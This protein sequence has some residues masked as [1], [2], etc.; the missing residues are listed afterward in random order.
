MSDRRPLCHLLYT[1]A[2]GEGGTGLR[3]LGR[4]PGTQAE[5]ERVKGW[6]MGLK[7]AD[8]QRVGWATSSFLVDR[9]SCFA[10][11]VVD[12]TRFPKDDIGRP[13]GILAH[14]L[15]LLLEQGQPVGDF[16]RAAFV[17]AKDFLEE[18]SGEPTL[19]NYLQGC[20]VNT[21]LEIPDL[22]YNNFRLDPRFLEIFYSAAC[23]GGRGEPVL[24]PGTSDDQLPEDLFTASTI[25]PPRLR[26]DLSWRVGLDAG[27]EG[28]VA[29]VAPGPVAS[30]FGNLGTAYL[31]AVQAHL[32][33][34]K[35]DQV[36]RFAAG[37]WNVRSWSG[38][39][40][41]IGQPVPEGDR[42]IVGPD[43]TALSEE[44]DMTKK[45]GSASGGKAAALTQTK[46]QAAYDEEYQALEKDL[47]DYL[48]EHLTQLGAPPETRSRP[49]YAPGGSS[50]GDRHPALRWYREWRPEVYFFVLLL[51]GSLAFWNLRS[52][53]NRPVEPT[54][55][56]SPSPSPTPVEPDP[57]PA[58][59]PARADSDWLPSWKAFVK[60][61]AAAGWFQAVAEARG[62]ASSQVSGARKADFTK[63]TD[64]IGKQER[65][66]D[67]ELAT[68]LTCFFEYAHARWAKDHEVGSTEDVVTN[69]PAEVA[70]NLPA[71][72]DDLGL[73]GTLGSHPEVS[74][75]KVQVEV[76]LAWIQRTPAEPWRQT[77]P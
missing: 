14:A 54:P 42:D 10:L 43:S 71:M 59:S 3:F 25:L 53:D 68:S 62:L 76:A 36:A 15:L 60:T 33:A 39:Q 47:R 32:R 40:Q 61:P 31:D 29:R 48:D 21:D 57:T 28:F 69:D 45:G 65:L 74:D 58:P 34:G 49:A 8:G 50:W 73:T 18:R 70:R 27:T 17:K 26:L 6:L 52:S 9:R 51:L 23:N 37:D 24:F 13:G 12:S 64:K 38:L 35:D 41:A 56:P 19:A 20:R 11:A 63:W 16:G 2:P 4:V 5:V 46:N 55:S 30:P 77:S 1:N 7:L 66:T 67:T 44:S 22:Q 72:I 75:P